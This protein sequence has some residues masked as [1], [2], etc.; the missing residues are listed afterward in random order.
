MTGGLHYWLRSVCL[1]PVNDIL[2]EGLKELGFA[3]RPM[4]RGGQHVKG[5][6]FDVVNLTLCLCGETGV[7]RDTRDDEQFGGLLV[8]GLGDGQLVVRNARHVKAHFL[9]DLSN[10]TLQLGL[11]L[12]NLALWEGPIVAV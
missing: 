12:V 11:M 8:A 10:C 9:L 5:N 3:R 4:A 1:H 6:P 7:L 2:E